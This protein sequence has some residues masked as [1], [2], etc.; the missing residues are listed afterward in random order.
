MSQHL[1][2][3]EGDLLKSDGTVNE[4]GYCYKP[5]LNYDPTLIKAPK[6]RIKHWDYY[7]IANDYVAVAFTLS[8]QTYMQLHTIGLIDFAK[9]D[10]KTLRELRVVNRPKLNYSSPNGDRSLDYA[11][12]KLSISYKDN[13]DSVDIHAYAPNFFGKEFEANFSLYDYPRDEMVIVTPFH[14][15]KYFYYNRKINCISVSGDIMLGGEKIDFNEDSFAVYDCGRGAWTMRNRWYWATAS[16]MV[17][18]KKFGLNFGYGFGDTSAATE[19]ILFFDGVAHKLNK[20]DI[21]IPKDAKGKE[22]Y[23]GGIWHYCDDANRVNLD[24]E[25]ITV[26]VDNVSAFGK[27]SRQNQTFGRFKGTV[28]LD[29]GRRLKIDCMG[30]CEVFDNKG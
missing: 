14:K 18:G 6:N 7:M 25:P 17:E 28:I 2:E 11:G 10:S 24:F 27:F 8:D 1:I 9:P 16:T 20:V 4:A 3:K 30:A 23:M 22:N 12:K 13:G 19:N 15:K 26:R 21:D 29:D 5:I